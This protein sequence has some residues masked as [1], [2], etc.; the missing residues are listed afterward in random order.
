MLHSLQIKQFILQRVISGPTPN[1][2]GWGT[3]YQWGELMNS[4]RPELAFADD[5]AVFDAIKSLL[6]SGHIKACK[7]RHSSNN[8]VF[9]DPPPNSARYD[10]DFFH[11]G[12]FHLCRTERSRELLE[13]IAA[14]NDENRNQRLGK[15]QK[16]FPA[17]S[18]HDAY[19]NIRRIIEMVRYNLFVI[20]M[21]VNK[22]LWILLS[23]ISNPCDIRILTNNTGLY[24]DFRLEARKFRDQYDHRLEIRTADTIHDRFIMA[25]NAVW[26]LGASLKDAGKKAFAITNMSDS[27]VIA[28]TKKIIEIEWE[29]A[30]VITI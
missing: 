9:Y 21:Y 2:S 8:F 29:K 30:T 15:D 10:D 16:I 14:R 20:D 28:D 4:V 18:D 5:D 27:T 13:E 25:D 23:N 17:N 11:R 22:D 1:G 7:Y 26:H 12:G 6:L 19:V 3:P 24:V